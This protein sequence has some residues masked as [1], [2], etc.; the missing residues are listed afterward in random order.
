L[1]KGLSFL[2][3]YL[4]CNLATAQPVYE[5]ELILT[6]QNQ[7]VAYRGLLL[8]TGAEKG[9][10]RLARTGLNSIYDLEWGP[11]WGDD[12]WQSDYAEKRIYYPYTEDSFLYCRARYI[13]R[14]SGNVDSEVAA[15]TIW[16]RKNKLNG[17][18]EPHAG[19][20]PFQSSTGESGG[21]NPMQAVMPMINSSG[22]VSGYAAGQKNQVVGFKKWPREN[23]SKKK[24]GLFF[25]PR[26]LGVKSIFTTSQL[27][28]A[29]NESKPVL[30][31]LMV[32]S[33]EKLCR[34]DAET[35]GAYFSDL[36]R[37]MN[38]PF[39]K[40]VIRDNDFNVKSVTR[41]IQSLKTSD[42]DIILF[43][44]SGH[45]FSY[46]DD[47]Q[48]PFPQ[49]A[50][51][52]GLT[53]KREFIRVNTINLEEIYKMILAK[54][55]RLR[56]VTG[57]CCNSYIDMRRQHTV[58]TLPGVFGP[59]EKTW[60][61]KRIAQLFLEPRQSYLMAAARK[62]EVA[63]SHSWYGGFFTFHFLETLNNALLDRL[64]GQPGWDIIIRKTGEDAHEVSMRFPCREKVCGQHMISKTGG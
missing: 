24:V 17:Q 4:F 16:F 32:H 57:D 56:I 62:G 37:F 45:G 1:K 20:I 46:M 39:R 61:H 31:L 59:R 35:T 36:C 11:Y 18:Y 23:L 44:Y 5:L 49:L 40:I 54:N 7:P 50:L 52:H 29:R 14:V 10:I 42:N 3:I 64:E 33:G 48:Y 26:E 2:F 28:K 9:F 21:D 58:P 55:G 22:S 13:R 53:A 12:E 6:E 63:A 30:H 41:A 25:T 19:N 27:I 38:I 47:E 60:N 15:L 51:W 8:R 43:T 34:D